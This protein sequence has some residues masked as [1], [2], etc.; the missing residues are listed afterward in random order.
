MLIGVARRFVFV[1][2]TKTAST[3]IEA[4]LG[5]VAEIARQGSAARKHVSWSRVREEYGFL[6]D[7]PGFAPESFFRFGV[8]R[9]PVDWVRSWYNYRLG[10]GDLP[11]A[12]RFEALWDAGDWVKR[13][14]QLSHFV[15]ADGEC[16]F[17]LLRPQGAVDEALPRICRMLGFRLPEVPRKNVSRHSLRREEIP[18]GLAA[19]INAHFAR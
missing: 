5:E 7:Q 8:L 6:F 1:A 2:N 11:S 18:E 3:S 19:R 17:D 13:K 14:D 12:T 16:L 9:E 15:D 10:R 4:A